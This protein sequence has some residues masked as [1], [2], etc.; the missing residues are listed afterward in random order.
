MRKEKRASAWAGDR[1]IKPFFR[2]Y[3][4]TLAL[5]L[6]LG[7]VAAFFAAALMFTSGYLIGGS[8]L[9]PA[10]ILLLNLPLMFVRIFGVG[11]PVLQYFERLASHD[12]VLRMTSALR[13]KLW[14]ALERDAVFFH[15]AHRMGDALG[16]LSEDIGH[17][18]NLYLRTVFPTVVAWALSLIV[19]AIFGALTP[20]A[21]AAM[22]LVLGVD[23][24]LVPL[25]SL[26]VNGARQTKRKQLK[27]RLYAD[28]AD[29]VLGVDDW[30]FSG[31]ADDFLAR[32][33]SAQAELRALEAAGHA[34]DRA[35]DL[36]VQALFTL[37]ALVVVAW[38]AGAFGPHGAGVL[39]G[40][41]N[42]MLAFA[43]GYF[44][45]LDAFAPLPVAAVEVRAHE[46]SL[47]RLNE[48]PAEDGEAAL[49]RVQRELAAEEAGEGAAEAAASVDAAGGAATADA[50]T[51]VAAAGSAA[52]DAGTA[53]A[54]APSVAVPASST[55]PAS[56]LPT[57]PFE[58][59]VDDV[60]FAYPGTERRV[61][62]GLTLR[63][64]PGQHVAVLGRSGS[65][66]STLASLIRGDLRPDKGG[67]TLGGA[68]TADL[69]DAAAR[70]FG[71]I[72]Q[73]TYLFNTTLRDNLRI[74]D[75]HAA[76]EDIA[77]VL[78]RVGLGPLLTRLPEGLD[79]LV[80]E[81]GLRFSGGERHRIA[82]ARVLL[83]DA[84]VVILDEPTVGLDPRTE[85][86][87]LDT[88]L[89]ALADKTLIMITHHLPG[90]AGM[91][92]VVFLE[93][94][95]VKRDG[96]VL[97]DAPPAQLAQESP[98]YRRLLAFDQG[99]RTLS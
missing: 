58:V 39:D 78:E 47:R 72:Q 98:H 53:A 65:G 94:G 12:W 57:P 2:Q 5:A 38:A 23:V 18:Q 24:V 34:F 90:V 62:D 96:A 29:N 30:V 37:G 52:T 95:R 17:I 66:K 61:I 36:A 46:D 64:E 31:R 28:L 3:K 75:P 54:A 43:L 86:A 67:V 89:E 87:V 91:D 33:A 4:K 84:S 82:L 56:P 25:W 8:A 81:E 44:P 41:A 40:S 60:A 7:I 83:Q 51:A 32:H 59:R 50:D 49:R 71:V 63:I 10:S 74:G 80:D 92:R 1:W 88:F 13:L 26:L 76:D 9:M 22:L 16:L 20:W 42:W 21:G 68:P 27:N 19:V 93:D 99:A 79:T 77:R 11:K 97:M 55:S 15:S 6:G 85:R 48:L 69:G 45:L 70:Y 35:R 73:R 14:G